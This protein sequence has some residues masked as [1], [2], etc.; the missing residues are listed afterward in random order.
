MLRVPDSRFTGVKQS[1]SQ[2]Q[3]E[4]QEELRKNEEKNKKFHLEAKRVLDHMEMVTLLYLSIPP[5]IG[6]KTTDDEPIWLQP[7]PK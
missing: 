1:N 2:Q 3:L 6:I 5:H 4:G 7:T